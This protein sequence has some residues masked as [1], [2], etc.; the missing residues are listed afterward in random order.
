MAEGIE[1]K[2]DIDDQA[3]RAML[4]RAAV[5]FADLKPA[6]QEIGERLVAST[7]YRAD[8][9]EAPDGSSWPKLKPATI[10]RHERAQTPSPEKALFGSSGRMLR[11]VHPEARAMELK[12]GTNAHTKRGF[13][14]PAVHQF[15]T[16]DGTIPKREWLGVSASDEVVIHEILARYLEAV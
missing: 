13:L 15:G 11:S 9:Q 14:Y 6:F 2:V 16:K 4:A 7:H 12:V 10:K 8:K 5:R 1:I 3:V